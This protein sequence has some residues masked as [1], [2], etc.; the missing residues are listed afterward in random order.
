MKSKNNIFMK[1]N[2]KNN[3]ENDSIILRIF[4]EI[5]LFNIQNQSHFNI[6]CL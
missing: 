3:I 5:I 2:Y 4:F 1:L 6:G